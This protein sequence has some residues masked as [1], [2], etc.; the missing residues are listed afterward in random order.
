MITYKLFLNGA[1]YGSSRNPEYMTELFRDYVEY[2]GMYGNDR[3]EFVVV[4][5][6]LT[7]NNNE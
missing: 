3:V 5:E 1:F 2:C 6:K 7:K 4:K